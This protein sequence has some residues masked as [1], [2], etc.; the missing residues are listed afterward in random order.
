MDFFLTLRALGLSGIQAGAATTWHGTVRVWL[1]DE[2]AKLCMAETESFG[3][4]A[5]WLSA[6][7]IAHFPDSPYARVRRFVADVERAI[8]A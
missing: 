7:A 8:Q 1:G 4:A 3:A 2:Q 6:Q 5:R